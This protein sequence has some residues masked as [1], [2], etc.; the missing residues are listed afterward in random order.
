ML[1][2]NKF[3]D[4]VGKRIG[5]DFSKL[6]KRVNVRN[7]K[8]DFVTVVK[9]YNTKNSILLDLGTG[10]GE[11]IISIAKNCKRAC[12]IDNSKFMIAKA[13]QNVKL[14][15]VE[16]KIGD[17]N[18]I[19]YQNKTFDIITS[20]HAPI[21]F[22]EAYRVMKEGGLLITQQ[23]G[24]RDKQNIK[25]VFGK[26]QSYGKTHGKLI[27]DYIKKAQDVGFNVLVKD[28]YHS[29]EYYKFPDLIF[30]LK[31]TPIIPEFNIKKDISFL[32]IIKKKFK[33]NLGIKTNS[34]RYLLIM[35]KSKVIS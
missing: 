22:K 15:N 20:R 1:N 34:C 18:D 12:G 27:S 4:S 29:I 21:N 13:K 9:K 19:P 23:V 7:R 30:L 24:E 5:W 35:K 2:K 17:N 33:S 31:N 8:W 26:G 16:F 32:E 10:S 28:H 25:D 11:K 3:Y 6:D 14:K